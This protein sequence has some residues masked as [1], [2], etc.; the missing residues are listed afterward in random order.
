MR[1]VLYIFTIFS[2]SLIGC[3]RPDP[4]PELK[5]EIYADLNSQLAET[6]RGISEEEKKREEH[7]KALLEVVPQTGQNKFANKRVFDSETK[8]T[9]LKQEKQWLELRIA[10][11]KASTKTK[12]LQAF[13]NKE[14]WPDPAEFEQYKAEKKMRN[15]KR[16]WDVRQRMDETGF[17][18][19]K[20]AT[21]K[22][23]PEGGEAAPK[24]SGH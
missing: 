15:A 21:T 11:R 12:Y 22:E 17:G 2:I 1:I 10:E 3:G 13:R 23:A 14:V 20:A 18:K 5:D 19:S 7:K 16:N 4:N 9:K 6:T 8:I 24:K